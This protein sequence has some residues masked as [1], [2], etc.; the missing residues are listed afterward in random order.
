MAK[1][2]GEC[3][4]KIVKDIRRKT[5]LGLGTGP[6]G[7]GRRLGYPGPSEADRGCANRGSMA[8]NSLF[9][10]LGNAAGKPPRRGANLA[11]WPGR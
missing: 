2:A 5:R 4:E 1:G 11:R 6:S 7:P 3:A 9:P 10:T 8:P